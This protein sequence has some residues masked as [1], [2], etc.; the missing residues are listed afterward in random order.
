MIYNQGENCDSHD[1]F[2]ST[3]INL[4]LLPTCSSK[5]NQ[6]ELVFSFIV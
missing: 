4:M 1:T 2:N 5:L 3:G 6:I